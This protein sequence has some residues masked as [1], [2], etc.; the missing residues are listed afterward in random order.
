MSYSTRILESVS[1]TIILLNRVLKRR[2]N[3]AANMLARFTAEEERIAA[4]EREFGIKLLLEER[5]GIHLRKV[6]VKHFDLD[7]Q[8]HEV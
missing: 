3:G 6:A 5:E 7:A 4:I 2:E 8:K 1:C